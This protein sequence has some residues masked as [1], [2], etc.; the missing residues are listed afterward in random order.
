[1]D[2]QKLIYEFQD[3][4]IEVYKQQN[5]T[6]LSGLDL[7]YI[8][9]G[10]QIVKWHSDVTD[11]ASLKYNGQFNYWENFDDILFCSEE[12]MY[13]TANLFLYRPYIN[14][15]IS[16]GFYFEGEMIYPNRQNL[17][18]KRYNMFCDVAGQKAYNYWEKIG[19]L[20]ASFFP[21]KFTN[22]KVYFSTAIKSIPDKFHS[23][24][25]FLWLKKFLELQ[26]LEL[27][28][29][30]KQIVHHSTSN[31]NYKNAHLKN[32]S[33]RGAM[34]QLHNEHLKLAD[35]YKSHINYTLIGFEKTLAFIEDI[36]PELFPV[37]R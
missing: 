36:N 33:D 8:V 20:I 21:E 1:M 17:E 2:N 34:S 3:S 32:A 16:D 26:Y 6:S 31:T 27:N 35:F 37:E 10:K 15:P 25:N 9:N 23:N 28:K 14:N 30:R 7:E 4:I 11:K 18:G 29:K 19:S 22:Q 24:E 13:F 12:L 5:L